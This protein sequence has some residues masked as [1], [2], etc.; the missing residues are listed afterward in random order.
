MFVYINL[1][2]AM[3]SEMK[4]RGH[5]VILNNEY[6]IHASIPMRNDLGAF[7]I[8]E[9]NILDDGKTALATFYKHHEIDLAEFNRPEE[10]ASILSGGYAQINLA[11]EEVEYS[12]DCWPQ[13]SGAIQVRRPRQF[14]IASLLL[15]VRASEGA[16][17]DGH[18][19][20]AGRKLAGP[21][22]GPHPPA[23]RRFERRLRKTLRVVE[24]SRCE[25]DLP[26]SHGAADVGRPCIPGRFVERHV[27]AK[28]SER[29]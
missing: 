3:Y 19:G 15:E 17:I 18:D 4:A 5:G 1:T 7:D 23:R 22:P 10:I 25:R 11:S 13:I 2:R 8:H 21:A 20:L 27:P 26:R 14:V 28:R 6:D 29:R 24:F 12:W 16:E 9:F